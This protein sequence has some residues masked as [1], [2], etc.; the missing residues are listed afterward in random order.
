MPWAQGFLSCWPSPWQRLMIILLSVNIYHPCGSKGRKPWTVP[1]RVGRLQEARRALPVAS[2]PL[3][4]TTLLVPS[5]TSWP[6]A[7]G[8]LRQQGP[9]SIRTKLL[10]CS[11]EPRSL[12][13]EGTP[14]TQR[15]AGAGAL[16]TVG[17]ADGRG[18]V[19]IVSRFPS[20]PL[21]SVQ[22]HGGGGMSWSP[23]LV[24][25]KTRYVGACLWRWE[26]T[27]GIFLIPC[28]VLCKCQSGPLWATGLSS[29]PWIWDY[30]AEAPAP[31][32]P[33]PGMVGTASRGPSL[34]R[35]SLDPWSLSSGQGLSGGTLRD[36]GCNLRS[37]GQCLTKPGWGTHSPALGSGPDPPSQSLTPGLR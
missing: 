33:P 29:E 36:R 16:T 5:P 26:Q 3:R 18:K 17:S 4:P 37:H 10:P 12:T 34:P 30:R 28:K 2:D 24:L 19:R 27:M 25:K 1:G 21:A 7:P 9:W 6:T 11:L 31:R 8:D 35:K 13:N 20:G 23:F 15:G 22:C 32:K 14:R